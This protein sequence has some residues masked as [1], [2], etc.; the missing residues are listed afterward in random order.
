MPVTND[1]IYAYLVDLS[2]NIAQQFA[3]V[4]TKLQDIQSTV[5]KTDQ[6]LTLEFA[7]TDNYL[8]DLS[9]NL[10]AQNKDIILLI[11]EETGQVLNS[12]SN[13]TNDINTNTNT[14]LSQYTNT[15]NTN[16]NASVSTAVSILN[17]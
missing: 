14:A 1:E 10:T 13:Q 15:I 3:E 17:K 8:T 6:T 5:G 12:I 7:A 2:A 16:T 9:A 11:A 4:D